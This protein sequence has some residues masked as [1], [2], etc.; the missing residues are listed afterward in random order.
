MASGPSGG[1]WPT[2]AIVAVI[3]PLPLR[4]PVGCASPATISHRF[5]RP[6]RDLPGWTPE[7]DPSVAD[8]TLSKT[9]DSCPLAS[10]CRPPPRGRNSPFHI[11]VANYLRAARV[12]ARDP[13]GKPN[14]A[15]PG[16]WWKRFNGWL[17]RGNRKVRY[18]GTAKNNHWLHHRAAALNLRRLLT[19][20]LTRTDTTWAIA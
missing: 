20:G 13:D 17:T 18:R 16:P 9:V 12:A 8:V 2:P 11:H 14:T 3:K 7:C 6:H 10:R 15:T 19:M 5:R 1:T 4:P